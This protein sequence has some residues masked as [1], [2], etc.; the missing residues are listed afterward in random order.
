MQVLAHGI[1]IVDVGEHAQAR[2][3]T[4]DV[5]SAA[6]IART[7]G[8]ASATWATLKYCTSRCARSIGTCSA[9]SVSGRE[10][11]SAPRSISMPST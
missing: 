2:R 5:A 3:E 1:E 10:T 8:T 4:I 9:A 11:T 6:M 7:T